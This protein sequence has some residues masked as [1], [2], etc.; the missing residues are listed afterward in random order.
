MYVASLYSIAINITLKFQLMKLVVKH[1]NSCVIYAMCVCVRGGG[2]VNV[3]GGGGV[4]V[5]GWAVLIVNTLLDRCSTEDNR[6]IRIS[7]YNLLHN[8]NWNYSNQEAEYKSD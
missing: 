1:M 4:N 6:T 2:G 8:Q 5:G 3:C 7:H